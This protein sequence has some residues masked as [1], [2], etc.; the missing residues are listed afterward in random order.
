[1]SFC[2]R[3][4]PLASAGVSHLRSSWG[5]QLTA[6]GAARGHSC[7]MMHA[8]GSDRV[9]E[10]LGAA[11]RPQHAGRLT[12]RKGSGPQEVMALSLNQLL[13][14]AFMSNSAFAQHQNAQHQV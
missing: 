9:S 10:R 12:G 14:G 7:C 11:M 5:Q 1:M 8:H 4:T 2:L 3:C 13:G 6:C